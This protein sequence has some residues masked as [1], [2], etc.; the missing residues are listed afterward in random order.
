MRRKAMGCAAFYCQIRRS[1]AVAGASALLV[2]GAGSAEAQS[3]CETMRTFS[4]PDVRITAAT[5]SAAPVPHCKV[6]GV[7]GKEIRFSVW[8]PEAWNG[9]FVMGGQGGFAG[10]VE[11]QAMAMGALDKGYA[12]A[13]TDTGHVGG[14]IDARWALGNLERIVNFGHAAVHRVAETAKA[15]VK[16]RYGR[17]AEKAYFAGCSNGGRQALMSAQ[18]YPEDFDA[19][20]A[21]APALDFAGAIATFMTITRAMYPDPAQVRP[22]TLSTGDLQALQKAVLATCDAADGLTDGILADPAACAF[23]PRAIACASGNQE[24]CLSPAEI[25]AVEA[26]TK[27][28]MLDGKPYLFGFPYGAEGVPRGGWENWLVGQADADGPGRPSLAY[29]FSYDFLRYFVKQDPAWSYTAFDLSTYAAETRVLQATI[30]PMDPDLSAF[31]SRGGKLLLYHGWADPA[32]SPFVT[33]RYMD[34][35]LARDATAA[36]DVRLF[37]LPGV[38]HCFDGP[39]PG[40]IDFLD[41]LDTWA[42]GG[43]APAELTAG[44][45]AGGGGRKVCAYPK[46]AVFTGGGDGRS[47][48]QFECR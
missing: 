26:I 20:L 5:A 48:D 44:F 12:V 10:T 24:G 32:L 14:A 16:A 11:S 15:A 41:T 47:P 29:G 28:P 33:T 13:G 40:R 21:G 19:I 38:L 22:P 23:D 45:A 7:I 18:R 9:K 43:P 36:G 6:D 27:G 37:M 39:G 25:A 4:A 3:A 42:R 35:V 46:K 34:A 30:S 8:L 17:S 1:F 31:R 2:A